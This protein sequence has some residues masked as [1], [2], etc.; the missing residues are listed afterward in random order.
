MHLSE[1]VPGVADVLKDLLAIDEIELGAVERDRYT[2]ERFKRSFGAGSCVS[3]AR[4]GHVK[5][6]VDRDI[7]R[8]KEVYRASR[9]AA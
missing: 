1:Q 8:A 2:V 7:A 9:S 3:F 6:A 5:A 4:I